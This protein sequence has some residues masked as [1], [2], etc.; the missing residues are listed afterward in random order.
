MPTKAT[1]M[2]ET[3]QYVEGETISSAEIQLHTENWEVGEKPEK[4]DVFEVKE[5]IYFR[6]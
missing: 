4:G 5:S 1:E 6:D 2:Q 3:I